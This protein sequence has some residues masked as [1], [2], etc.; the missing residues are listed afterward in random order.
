VLLQYVF[1]LEALLNTGGE[2]IGEKIAVRTALLTG[3][4]DE[5]RLQTRR[6][7]KASYSSRSK[8]AH[9]TA[10][11][12]EIDLPRLRDVCRRAIAVSVGIAG[13]CGSEKKFTD[14]IEEAVVSHSVQKDLQARGSR[15]QHL[16]KGW[17]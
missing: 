4:S 16:I 8:L 11:E 1:A 9:G 13:S 12:G 5:E 6:V 17:D 14:R 2:A 15:I 10:S 7:L 3:R